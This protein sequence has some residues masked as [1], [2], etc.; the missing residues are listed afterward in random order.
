MPPN[1]TTS[2]ADVRDGLSNTMMISECM[3]GAPW[4]GRYGNDGGGYFACLS[5]TAPD[6][7]ADTL[8]DGVL[9]RALSTRAGGEVASW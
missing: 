4:T 5:G 8:I 7:D 2:A 6:L 3:V 9:W 1:S